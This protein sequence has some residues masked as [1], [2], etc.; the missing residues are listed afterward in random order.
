M[1]PESF[2]QDL[3]EEWSRWVLAHGLP[4]IPSPD[5]AVGESVPVAY[6]IGTST[7]AVLHIRWALWD[8]DEEPMT[9]ADVELFCRSGSTWELNGGGGGQWS[10]ESS[11]SPTDVDP[12]SVEL[13]GTISVWSQDRGCKALWGSVGTDAA[14]AEVIQADQVTRRP[15]EAP[16]GAFVV[17]A[18]YAEAFIVRILD[19]QGELLVEVEEP[20]GSDEEPP[21]PGP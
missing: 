16:V 9:E 3:S 20:A 17:C 19:A 12:R 13:D 7:A 1:R 14:I 4:E 18:D 6:W 21:W 15:V 8:D 11:L 2:H 5:L 10:M